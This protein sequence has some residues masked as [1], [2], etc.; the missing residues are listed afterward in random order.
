MGPP[1][2][3]ARR[4]PRCRLAEAAV[5][6]L[7]MVSIV[8]SF[9]TFVTAHVALIYG[10]FSR[11]PAWQAVLAVPLFPLAAYYG[12]RE[13][14]RVRT[15]LWVAAALAYVAARVWGALFSS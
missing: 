6:A 13:R 1:E 14:L 12:Y 11:R 2:R 5:D 4:P 7:V 15:A 9:A 3:P 10:L 8:A